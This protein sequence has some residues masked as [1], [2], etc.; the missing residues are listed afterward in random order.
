MTEATQ[1]QIETKAFRDQV[2]KWTESKLRKEGAARGVPQS[3]TLDRT[4]LR[5]AIV[6]DERDHKRSEAIGVPQVRSDRH[7]D[8][9]RKGRR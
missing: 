1:I 5:E 9:P 7:S 3:E 6:S 8:A 4:T 2:A